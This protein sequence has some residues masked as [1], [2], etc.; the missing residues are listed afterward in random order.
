MVVP[1]D[2]NDQILERAIDEMEVFPTWEEPLRRDSCQV[3]ILV[4]VS[5]E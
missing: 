5:S 1:D 3:C 4:E 2:R